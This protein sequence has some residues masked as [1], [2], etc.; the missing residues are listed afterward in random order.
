M[1]DCEDE[2]AGGLVSTGAL[3][4]VT[5]TGPNGT[6]V[7]TGRGNWAPGTVV[8]VEEDVVVLGDGLAVA[9]RA[10]LTP[11]T[12]TA[13]P[14]ATTRATRTLPIAHRGP[15]RAFIRRSWHAAGEA[16]AEGQQGPGPAHD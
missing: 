15:R 12:L 13:M 9:G 11:T 14:M 1:P 3:V 6:V 8:V 4:V 2:S 7:V 16:G 5:Y 10:P